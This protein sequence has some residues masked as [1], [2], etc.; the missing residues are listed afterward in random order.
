MLD[1]KL[2][3]MTDTLLEDGNGNQNDCDKMEKRPEINCMTFIK[4]KYKVLHLR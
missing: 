2:H 3:G 4:D 1:L